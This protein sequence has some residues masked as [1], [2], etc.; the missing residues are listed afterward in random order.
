MVKPKTQRSVPRVIQDRALTTA[1]LDRLLQHCHVVQTD[2][3]SYRVRK[4]EGLM[5]KENS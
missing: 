5:S 3:K 4:L 1:I 2:G